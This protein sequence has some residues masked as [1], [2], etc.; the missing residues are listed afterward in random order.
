[1][2]VFEAIQKRHS[3]RTYE[4]TTIQK[5]KLGRILEAARQAPSAG[6]IQPWHFIIVTD[7]EKRTILAEGG[8]YA[9]PIAEAPVVIVGCGDQEASPKWYTVDVTI[10]LEH[11]ALAAASEDLGTCWIG[12][13]MESQVK[14]L[15]K[16]PENFRVVALLTL[17]YPREKSGAQG[18]T[19][20]AVR[21]RKELKEIVS[22]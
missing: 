15:L 4:S 22:Y 19:V 12:S 7:S 18:K 11:I 17:G 10:A 2:D 1:M 20:P 9:K 21:E 6:N 8:R 13:F 5:K 3:V 16:I 14:E